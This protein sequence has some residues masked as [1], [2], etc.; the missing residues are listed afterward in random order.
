MNQ[1]DAIPLSR[2]HAIGHRVEQPI[3][4]ITSEDDGLLLCT[5]CVYATIGIEHCSC[6]HIDRGACFYR[7]FSRH[8]H[9]IIQQ[10]WPGVLQ[11]QILIYFQSVFPLYL[12]D[13]LPVS[14]QFDVLCL[15]IYA[16]GD[17]IFYQH[18]RVL[19]EWIDMCTHKQE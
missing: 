15:A 18:G 6:V 13:I 8:C 16:Q 3:R 4:S 19:I 2:S 12:I 7:Q 5:Q 9:R 14:L 10:V 11:C 1:V 17:I